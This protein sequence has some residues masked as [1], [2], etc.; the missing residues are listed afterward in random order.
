M[1]RQLRAGIALLAFLGG[2]VAGGMQYQQIGQTYPHRGS[3][4]DVR[5]FEKTEPPEQYDRIGQIVWDYSRRKFDAPTLR[6]ILPDM[7]QKAWEVGGDALIIRDLR[8][9]R[10]PEGTLHVVADVVRWK[11]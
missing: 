9:P 8:E 6:E 11:R 3:A 4:S 7:K 2:C 10:D 1:K 5:I